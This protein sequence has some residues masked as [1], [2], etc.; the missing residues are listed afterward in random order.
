MYLIVEKVLE[1]ALQLLKVMH[2]AKHKSKS[3]FKERRGKH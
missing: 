3:V 2:N 1:I